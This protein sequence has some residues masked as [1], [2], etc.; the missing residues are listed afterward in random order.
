MMMRRIFED[1][2]GIVMDENDQ[3]HNCHCE[4]LLR[5]HDDH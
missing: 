3:H 2:D 5:R 1:Y 4:L